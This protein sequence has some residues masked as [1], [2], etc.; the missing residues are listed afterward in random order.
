M[1]LKPGPLQNPMTIFSGFSEVKYC[2][3]FMGRSKKGLS[4]ELVIIKN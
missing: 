2:I 3:G 4:G 1:D